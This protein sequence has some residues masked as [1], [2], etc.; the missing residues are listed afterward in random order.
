[1]T[2]E[3]GVPGPVRLP[4]AYGQSRGQYGPNQ[5]KI[6]LLVLSSRG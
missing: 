5:E 6:K 1:M 2:D 3:A 4:N